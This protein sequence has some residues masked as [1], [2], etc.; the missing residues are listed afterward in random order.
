MSNVAAIY[1]RK[2]TEQ[3]DAQSVS[4]Q[5]DNAKAFAKARG[6][7][8]GPIFKDDGVSGADA[9]K[10]IDR[11]RLLDA[12]KAKQF[13]VVIMQAQDRFSRGEEGWQEIKQLAKH[14]A[15]W[16]YSD[17]TQFEHGSFVPNVT[18]FLKA[19]FAAE[20]RRAIAT[21]TH[22]AMLK[23][24][25]DGHATGGK[26]FGYD[27]VR[28][29]G[30]VDREI[31]STEA[32][33]VRD[34]FARYAAGE[35]FKQIAHALNAQK[36]P[37]PR[38]QRGRPAG[39]DP[40]TIR[41]VL[42]RSIYRGLVIY[43]KTKK[44]DADG[45]RHRGRQPKRPESEWQKIEMPH[46]RLLDDALIEQVDAKLAGKRHAYLRSAKGHLLGRPVEGKH[47]LAGFLACQCGGTF[48]VVRGQYVCSTR[49]R[50]GVSVCASTVS[51]SATEIERTFLDC[52][53]GTVLHPDFIDRLVDALD[54][55]HPE[56]E[57]LLLERTT[58]ARE[59]SNLTS[60]I[61]QG[62]DIPALATALRER[63]ARLK[64]LDKRLALPTPD[65]PDREMLRA[66]LRLREGQWRDVLRSQH[67]AQARQVLAHLV[68]LPIRILSE[69]A[70]K[71][72]T[73]SKPEGILVG[74]GL[75]Q[76]MASPAGQ[77]DSYSI[78]SV[79]SPPGFEPGFQP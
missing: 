29:N 21:K 38:P 23:K 40:G 2:S 22:E 35:G 9:R 26:V 10:L 11:A 62:G 77:E 34:I 49:R 12:A 50:K 16:F 73:L 42:R 75:I 13:D 4:R 45:A 36:C 44:R 24:A 30:H 27:H 68:E 78:Q 52:I 5:I 17:G 63:D 18:G 46:L 31:N 79:A 56:R 33:V 67:I 32:A 70:P 74:M 54:Q 43:N 72:M 7:S 8:V 58:L 28:R 59:I 15:I 51:I 69:P 65:A 76:S 25:R 57:D 41:A 6:W 14:V 64:S 1:A 20:F 3:T 47:L 60:A 71:W 48:E 53:E 19:E 37:S 61:A 39:W 55:P 66:A